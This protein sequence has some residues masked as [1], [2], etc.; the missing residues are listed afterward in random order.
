MR[1]VFALVTGQTIIERGRR[2]AGETRSIGGLRIKK[3]EYI[4]I[5]HGIRVNKVYD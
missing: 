5:A 2:T 4:V 3:R 1:V